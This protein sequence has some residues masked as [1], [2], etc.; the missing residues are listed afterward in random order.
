[1]YITKPQNTGHFNVGCSAILNRQFVVLFVLIMFGSL[2]QNVFTAFSVVGLA[3][4]VSVHRIKVKCVLYS[5]IE[6]QQN[7][8]SISDAYK[9][10]V[11]ETSSIE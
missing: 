4:E 8:K 7:R 5:T 9:F 3:E 6:F 2:L 11:L 1:M 10:V